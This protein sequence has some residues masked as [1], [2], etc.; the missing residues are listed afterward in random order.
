MIPKWPGVNW[1]DLKRF[2]VEK[3]FVAEP[4]AMTEDLV[5][6]I[7]DSLAGHRND[8]EHPQLLQLDVIQRHEG[9]RRFEVLLHGAV[10][11]QLQRAN[12]DVSLGVVRQG[13]L[14]GI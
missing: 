13:R 1:S 7:G 11:E 10:A 8:A 2:R 5:T 12:D 6:V 4:G 3:S 9:L 14:H